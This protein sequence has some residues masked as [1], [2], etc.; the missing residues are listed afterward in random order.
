MPMYR[1]EGAVT[2]I[3]QLLRPEFHQQPSSLGSPVLPPRSHSGSVD[4]DHSPR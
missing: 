2:N 1:G 3:A 4:G